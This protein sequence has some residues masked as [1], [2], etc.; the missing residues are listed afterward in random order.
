MKKNYCHRE[1]YTLFIIIRNQFKIFA[2]SFLIFFLAVFIYLINNVKYNYST[3]LLVGEEKNIVKDILTNE[4]DIKEEK[5]VFKLEILFQHTLKNDLY[6][7]QIC[8]RINNSD[9]YS[10]KTSRDALENYL[11]DNLYIN[12]INDN[13]FEF[14]CFSNKKEFSKKILDAALPL[15]VNFNFRNSFYFERE[16]YLLN[17]KKQVDK[18]IVNLEE[19]LVKLQNYYLLNMNSEAVDENLTD[20]KNI[21]KNLIKKKKTKLN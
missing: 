6:I 14:G 20:Y 19:S 7:N 4:N 3:E 18:A 8:E 10:V 5:N 12:R 21:V 11:K 13:V 15:F 1:E 17:L 16:K 2:C 9:S